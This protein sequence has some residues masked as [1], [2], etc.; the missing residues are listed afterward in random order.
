MTTQ[1]FIPTS[2]LSA[3]QAFAVSQGYSTRPHSSAVHLGIQIKFG[4]EWMAVV[5]NSGF[6]RY[7]VDKRL[8][9]LLVL[10]KRE[11]E[12]DGPG[13]YD[14]GLSADEPDDLYDEESV[15]DHDNSVRV[16]PART[17]V[18]PARNTCTR[19][20]TL[21]IVL[22]GLRQSS[23]TMEVLVPSTDFYRRDNDFSKETLSYIDP[24]TLVD[25]LEEALKQENEDAITD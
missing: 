18:T 6:K 4:T 14:P 23:R 11:S 7:T 20:S 21:A 13:W 10:Y 8:H 22:E 25:I 17:T 19:Q 2:E 15:Y 16:T 3:F 12:C 1:N 24:G 5:W 9:E